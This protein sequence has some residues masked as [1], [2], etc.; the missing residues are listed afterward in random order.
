VIGINQQIKSRSG[1]GEGVG[2]AVPVDAVKRSLDMLRRGGQAR[3]AYLGVSSVPLYPQLVDRFQ[4]DADKGAWVQQVTP[5]GPAARAGIRGGRGAERFQAQEFAAG[6]DVITKVEGRP[7]ADSS[8]RA[9]VV[10]GFAPGDNV[11]LEIRRDGD[12]SEV[13]VRLGERPLGNPSG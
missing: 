1:G 13:E 8:D 6:G 11:T 3:Y 10:A 7:V 2:F 5:G 9:E 4:L 12:T